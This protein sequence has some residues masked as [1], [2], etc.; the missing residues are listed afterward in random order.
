MQNILV[1][2]IGNICRS[3][4]GEALLAREFPQMK[5]WSAGLGALVGDPADPLSIEVAA[6]QGL[7]LSAHRAQQIT[8]WMCQAA[9]LILVMEQGHKT[10]LEQRFPL[11]RGKVFRLG[12][13]DKFDIA[14]PHRQ[15]K[16]AFEAAYADI[17]RGVSAWVPRIRQLS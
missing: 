7:D 8:N 6:A 1:V 10:E 16:A 4:I 2:C 15:P 9:D 12:E 14:D 3:P 13:L 11:V 5:V 17:S